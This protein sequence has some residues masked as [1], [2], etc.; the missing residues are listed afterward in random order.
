MPAVEAIRHTSFPPVVRPGARV[1]ILGSMPGAASLLAQQYYAHPH[2]QFWPII[3]QIFGIARTLPYP[4][5]LRALGLQHVALWDVLESCVRPGSLDAAI[6]H[7][8]AVP[9]ALTA[10]LRDHPGI[11]R[12]CCNGATAYRAVRRYF[13]AEFERD[14]PRLEYL[15][16][17]STSPAHAGMRLADKAAAWREALSP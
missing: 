17:P 12:L 6:E 4:A 14:F 16:L 1:L 9:N 7:A 13:G 10:L 11:T 3:E 15:R 5:R 2:N 8:T